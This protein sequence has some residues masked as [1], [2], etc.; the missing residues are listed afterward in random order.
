MEDLKPVEKK[1]PWSNEKK[2]QPAAPLQGGTGKTI[3]PS[4]LVPVLTAQRGLV[5]QRSPDLSVACHSPGAMQVLCRWARL[6]L[7]TKREGEFFFFH[8]CFC[9]GI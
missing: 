5:Q 4:G 1:K 3:K 7:M 2:I 9:L 6:V 8:P